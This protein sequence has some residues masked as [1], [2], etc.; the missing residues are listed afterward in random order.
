MREDGIIASNINKIDNR[1]IL[2][3]RQKYQYDHGHIE[4][5][6]EYNSRYNYTE[7]NP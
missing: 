6:G 5:S 4:G 3:V 2:D 1:L 7:Q